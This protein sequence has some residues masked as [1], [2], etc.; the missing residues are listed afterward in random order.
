MSP[1]LDMK[2]FSFDTHRWG[3]SFR[4]PKF[5]SSDE[6]YLSCESHLCDVIADSKEH[7][8]RSCS[9]KVTPKSQ[10]TPNEPLPRIR[11][12]NRAE[13]QGTRKI[14]MIDGPFRVKDFGCGPLIVHQEIV[15]SFSDSKGNQLQIYCFTNF[16]EF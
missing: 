3:L 11:R 2:F 16:C 13:A 9:G 1:Q 6:I 15:E 10:V 7:C 8:D 14:Q 4:M 5:E 12:Q